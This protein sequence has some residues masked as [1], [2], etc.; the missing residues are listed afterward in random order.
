MSEMR[1][2]QLLRAAGLSVPS[3]DVVV[4]DLVEDSRLVG[5]GAL[6]VALRGEA[7]DARRFIPNAVEQGAVAVVVDDVEGVG[8]VSVPLIVVDNARRALACLAHAWRDHPAREL[9][10]VGVT[11]TNGKTTVAHYVESILASAGLR[12]GLMGTIEHRAGKRHD[13]SGNTT[14]SPL[15]IARLL[16]D[17]RRS[18]GGAAALEV[19]SHGIDQHRVDGFRFSAAIMTNLS[20][21]HLDYH[22][23]MASYGAVKRRFFFGRAPGE[24][25]EIAAFNLEDEF[26]ASMAAEC[27]GNCVTYG[28]SGNADVYARLIDVGP[29]GSDIEILSHGSATRVHV[30]LPGRFN[31]LNALAA[32]AATE[33]IG[34]DTDAIRSG[35]DGL[36]SVPGRFET[37]AAGQPFDIVVDYAHTPDALERVLSEARRLCCGQLTTVLGCGGDRDRGKRPLCGEVAARICDRVIV[38]NCNPRTED[39]GAIADAI[40]EGVR[41][42]HGPGASDYSIE[43]ERRDAMRIAFD[44]AA[45]GDLIVVAGRGHEPRQLFGDHSRVFDDRA[46]ARE[47]LAELGYSSEEG[48]PR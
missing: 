30:A 1:L 37:I 12:P 11:G 24:K 19:S 15:A 41:A 22:G 46:V 9:K 18:G 47:L 42:A 32:F 28:L 34:I 16:D 31:I 2:K 25:P 48:A 8:N 35:L 14:P 33:A 20:Q 45:K 29:G 39:P 7:L 27:E 26:S 36:K 13:V 40:V 17:V 23:D 10:V 5:C 21:D 44:G 38:T 43:L 4:S 3:P 6:F